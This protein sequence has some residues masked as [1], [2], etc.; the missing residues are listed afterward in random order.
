[1]ESIG[2]DRVGRRALFGVSAFGLA[3]GP[4]TALA[5][6]STTQPAGTQP[7]PETVMELVPASL[8]DGSLFSLAYWQWLG[9]LAVVL[10]AVV[11]DLAVRTL[12]APLV[13]RVVSRLGGRIE[14]DALRARVRTLGLFAAGVVSLFGLHLLLLPE[15]AEPVLLAIARVFTV[16]AATFAGLGMVNTVAEV[17]Q[18]R[19]DRTA[20]KFDD[21]LIPLVRKTLKIFVVVL[22]VI[23]AAQSL[24]INI[25]PLITGLGIGGLA[26]AFAAKDTVENFFGSVAVVLDRPFEVGDWVVVDDIEGTVEELGFRSTRVR[27]FYNSQ[28]TIP[29]SNLVRANV[30][31]MGRRRYRR[32]RTT[33]GVQY[34]TPPDLLLAFTEGIRELVRTHPYTRKDYYQVWMHDWADS[35]MNVLLYVFFEVPDWNTELR[36]RERLFVDI[37]R[38]ADRLG[39]AFAF[40]TRT[41]HLFREKHQAKGEA[42]EPEYTTPTSMSDRRAMVSGIRAAQAVVDKQAW[43]GTKPPP[44]T[45]GEAGL[46]PLD[47]AGNET[48][49]PE[50]AEDTEPKPVRGEHESEQ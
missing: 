34:D 44:Q 27:T 22:G 31:N 2:V 29:N 47:D 4:V 19:A 41:L 8:R 7:L 30:D 42:H 49:D 24:S 3:S 13:R 46:T 37:V 9:L 43:L 45:Y 15:P 17:L 5:N 40:P 10:L 11:T 50:P 28:V 20:T 32:W 25:V 16:L 21:V 38:L 33:I 12:A 18:V 6:S 1:M 35:S 48:L 36:E 39:V 14:S 23:Y 26:F